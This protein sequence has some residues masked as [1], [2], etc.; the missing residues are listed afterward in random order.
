MLF[1]RPQ[2]PQFELHTHSRLLVVN[3]LG[4][5]YT[6]C[7][8][9][10]KHLGVI[11]GNFVTSTAVSVCLLHVSPLTRHKCGLK[12]EISFIITIYCDQF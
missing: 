4:I 9:L 2:V 12:K 11:S 8:C 10:L 7:A 5:V 6:C 1:E 3:I